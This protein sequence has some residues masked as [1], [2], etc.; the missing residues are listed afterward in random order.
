M[1]GNS[2][3]TLGR[4]RSKVFRRFF[5]FLSSL[6]LR[7]CKKMASSFY[8]LSTRFCTGS[9]RNCSSVGRCAALVKRASS[10]LSCSKSAALVV[11]SWI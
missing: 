2:Q 5:S 9:S 6:I 8:S 10:A 1:V 3:A 4:T 11:I 7:L